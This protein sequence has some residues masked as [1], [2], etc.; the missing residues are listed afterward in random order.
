[1]T[2][3]FEL[4]PELPLGPL[5][6]LGVGGP[7]RYFAD[8]GTRAAVAE[9]LAWARDHGL[10]LTLLAGGSNV[11]VSDRGVDALVVRLGLAAESVERDG[12][13]VEVCAGAGQSWDGFVR[14]AVERGWS[15]IEC[16]SG[17]P[18]HVG[19]TPIQNVGAYGQEISDTLVSVD[20]Y[21]RAEERCVTL[22]ARDCGLGYRTSRF[23]T[24][25]AARFIVLSARFRL[26]AAEPQTPRYPELARQFAGGRPPSL[27]RI[28]EVVLTT[29]RSKS[30][31]LEPTD[32]NGRSCGSFFVNPKLEPHELDRLRARTPAPPPA[33]VEADGRSKVPAA[34]LIEHAGFRKGERWGAV[35][36]SS[37]HALALVC[38][39]GATAAQLVEAAHRIRD[40]VAEAFGVVLSPEPRFLGFPTGGD[41]LPPL[42]GR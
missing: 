2:P 29:R 26:S 37:K 5:T 15:G 7:A 13:C 16:L 35:G 24:S 27:G 6:T 9:A 12:E 30:M 23:K 42:G 38:H 1:M 17:I 11:V 21:D 32:E 18:G 20:V 41:G 22:A 8:L 19:A 14:R 36:I 3:S 39:D 4:R 25:D 31:L 34:W 40:G 28:R 33:F 10:E